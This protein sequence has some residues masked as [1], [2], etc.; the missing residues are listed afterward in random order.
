MHATSDAMCL[1]GPALHTQISR[2]Q[3]ESEQS[4][5]AE[6]SVLAPTRA[7]KKPWARPP[8]AMQFTVG[9]GL[10]WGRVGITQ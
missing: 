6:V 10:R 4:L 3:G 8:I 9:A 7:E 5:R 1:P 2:F